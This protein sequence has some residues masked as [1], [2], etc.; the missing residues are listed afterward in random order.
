LRD[1]L[2]D[3]AMARRE[4]AQLAWRR[5]DLAAAEREATQALALVSEM[6]LSPLAAELLHLRGL[7]H[8]ARNRRAEAIAD[9]RAAVSEVERA[10]GALQAERFR[11]AYLGNRLALYEDLAQA[12]LDSADGGAPA[13]AFTTIELA[14]SRA[15]LDLS[16]GALERIA[17]AATD[18]VDSRSS[19]IN[20]RV[21]AL[22]AELNALYSQ[23]DPDDRPRPHAIAW[24]AWRESVRQREAELRGLQDRLGMA[25]GAAGLYARPVS[26]HE[27]RAALP[28]GT[29]VVEYFAAG[30]EWLA[31]A[32]TG[33]R[34]HLL[35]WL[36]DRAELDEQVKRM[37]FQLG[38]A[39]RG[40]AAD[41]ARGARLL[42]DARREL[43]ALWSC[44][45][46]PVR[47]AVG[48][49]QRLIIIPYGPLHGVPFH[50][51]WDGAAY[52]IEGSDVS[53]ALS[54]T[55]LTDALVTADTDARTPLAEAVAVGVADQAAP[56]IE[57]EAVRIAERIPGSRLLRG[58]SATVEAL[59]QAAASA[60]CLHLACH[61]RFAGDSPLSSGLKLYDR[62]LTTHDLY[63]MHISARLV[64]LS[65]CS[66][67]RSLVQA[68]DEVLGLLRGF[69][70][71]GVRS[72]I[73]TLWPVDDEFAAAQMTSFYT[74]WHE[75][76]GAG[77]AAAL[78][79]AQLETLRMNPHPAC[80]APF[81][82]VGKP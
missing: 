49:V 39:Q 45:L 47:R 77:A 82:L 79:R 73:A 81:V 61:G 23:L 7:I 69:L 59:T 78:R 43:H 38:R 67:G 5:G 10:R 24:S 55:L 19:Q 68:G 11:A 4:L 3:T 25:R 76:W 46:A 52:V 9:M 65:G 31:L 80:W 20:R 66:T 51:L 26:L 21:L 37:R 2:V 13:D 54:G 74:M 53:Y 71:A 48:G 1:R 40:P 57:D 6:D 18:D 15:L 41:S 42:A 28:P 33:S 50:A 72:V 44:L 35:R 8:R 17:A 30:D 14:R 22:Q 75:A 27:L 36:A 16:R 29:C 62:W 60:T 58:T 70:A 34:T 32:I 64:T 12:Q 63:G 56:R